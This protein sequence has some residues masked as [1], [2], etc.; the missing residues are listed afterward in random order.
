M[1]R[2]RPERKTD[3]SEIDRQHRQIIETLHRL[4][5]ASGGESSPELKSQFES[6][7]ALVQ[8]HFTHEEAILAE[9]GSDLL[10]IQQREHGL[11]S[12]M[13]SNMRALLE[14]SEH[15]RWRT[16]VVDDAVDALTQH[17]TKE[18][19]AFAPQGCSTLIRLPCR[20]GYDRG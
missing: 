6:F 14:S 17:F 10:A 13:L 4:I 19:D 2:D 12:R 5:V 7:C 3:S 11:L 16:A 9:I 18:D 15:M 20:P 1:E 8:D